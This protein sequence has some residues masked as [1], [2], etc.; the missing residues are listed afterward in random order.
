MRG[1]QPSTGDEVASHPS[2][3]DRDRYP[4]ESNWIDLPEGRVHYVDEG[5]GATSVRPVSTRKR[6]RED[7]TAVVFLHGNPTWSFL[8]RHLVR[9]LSEAYRCVAPDLLGFGLSAAPETFTYLPANHARVVERLLESLALDEVVVVVH[10]WGGPL[11]L[12]YATRNPDDVAGI[13]AM[14]TWCWPRKGRLDRTTSRL[15][16]TGLARRLVVDHDAFTQLAIAP[17]VVSAISRGQ[18]RR[19]R[20]LRRHYTCPNTTKMARL[21]TWTFAREVDRSREW[22]EAVWERRRA[23]AET[24]ICLLWGTE[25]PVQRSFVQRWTRVFPCARATTFEDVGHFV[26]EEKGRELV[27][28]VREFLAQQWGR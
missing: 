4:F 8:Y 7:E 27:S 11:G 1:T 15:L 28:P 6:R 19:A 23:L 16:N 3:L 12:D 21:A 9:E 25:D 18:W 17:L 20:T 2:W 22:L 13:V 14:N 26:P 24:P 5:P 10:D